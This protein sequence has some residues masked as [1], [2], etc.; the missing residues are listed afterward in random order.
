MCAEQVDEV[1]HALLQ[2]V[3][4]CLLRSRG[5]F[6]GPGDTKKPCGQDEHR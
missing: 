5:R 3:D 6:E 1:L 2:R 4:L